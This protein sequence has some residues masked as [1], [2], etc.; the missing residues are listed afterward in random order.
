MRNTLNR[1]RVSRLLCAAVILICC[2]TG[3]FA[4][5]NL[6]L[7]SPPNS[8]Y[9]EGGVYTSPYNISVNGTATQLICDDFTTDIS[10]GTW[11]ATVSTITTIDSATVAGFK[12]DSSP[13]NANILGG[14]A[15]VVQ[16]YA[17][18]AVLAA[19]LLSLPNTNT[20]EAGALSFAL[21]DVFD[22]SLLGSSYGTMSDPYGPI[23]KTQWTNAMTDLAN[24]IAQVDGV[25][26]GGTNAGSVTNPTSLANVEIESGGSVNLS[27]LNISGLTVYTPT[28]DAS[29]SQE[30]LHVTTPEAST[31]VLLAVDLFGF[32]AIAA[33]LRKRIWRSI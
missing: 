29:V 23:D 2:A 26:T 5:A 20:A 10:G 15:N 31:P 21:W 32:V 1:P 19:E 6:Q 7:L 14:A 25:M 12:F 9:T 17:V 8:G 22:P 30:F 11:S 28:P 4:D 16:D 33:F 27:S 3:A 13:Y 18:A 24:A